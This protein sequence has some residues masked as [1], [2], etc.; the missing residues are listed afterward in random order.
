MGIEFSAIIISIFLLGVLI[1]RFSY[2]NRSS[3][4]QD[5]DL[6]NYSESYIK[7]LNFLLAN[8]SDKAIQ[9]FVDLIKVDG[10]TIETHLALGNLFR[11]KGEVDRAIKI[12]QNL[13]ARP[14]LDQNQRVMALSEL[15]EDYL[16]AGL[17][18]RAEN[19]YRELVEINPE[20]VSAQTKLLELFTVEKSWKEALAVAQVLQ[21]LGVQDS[22]LIVTHCYCEIAEQYLSEGNL[23]EARESL[24]KAIK[25]DDECIRASLLLIDV[26]LKNN[27]LAKAT[28]LLKQQ[29]KSYPQMIEFY[30][31]PAREIYLKAGSSEQY[32]RF[33]IS[34]YEKTPVTKV[35]MELLESYQAA[36]KHDDVAL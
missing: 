4:S 36:D 21:G 20:N 6:T 29:L 18:D 9:L 16:K 3:K 11:S 13:I 28:R 12:H 17:L 26:H 5:T 35:A 23:R 14:N 24:N 25:I 8:K 34:Q 22:K 27:E 7:G 33:L 31:K 10:E 32:Q 2:S 15:A 19:L 30:I 1:G